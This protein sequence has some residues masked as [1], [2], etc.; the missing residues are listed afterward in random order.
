MAVIDDNHRYLDSFWRT[1]SGNPVSE[2]VEVS[3]NMMFQMIDIDE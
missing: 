3:R 1:K 2:S